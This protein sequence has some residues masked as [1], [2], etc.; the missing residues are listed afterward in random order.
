M[1][2]MAIYFFTIGLSCVLFLDGASFG[3]HS[4]RSTTQLNDTVLEESML[5]VILLSDGH[6]CVFFLDRA[7]FEV[8]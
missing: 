2:D 1:T 8:H 4:K 3:V 7:S 5:W 6:S